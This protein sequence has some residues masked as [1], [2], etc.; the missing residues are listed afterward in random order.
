MGLI[1][2]VKMQAGQL[3]GKA[4]EVGKSLGRAKIGV[5]RAKK[6]A[7]VHLIL[8]SKAKIESLQAKR[9]A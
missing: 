7:I 2:K 3:V 4:E 5:F 1:N 6:R 9:H 8:L